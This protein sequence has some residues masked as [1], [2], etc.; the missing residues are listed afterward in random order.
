L[1]E[2]SMIER[3]VRRSSPNRGGVCGF[4][5]QNGLDHVSSKGLA[6]R[7]GFVWF[8]WFVWSVWFNQTNETNE[9][10]QMN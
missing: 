3:I 10:D 6:S 5:R 9:I 8:I 1:A 7:E 4:S 2:L